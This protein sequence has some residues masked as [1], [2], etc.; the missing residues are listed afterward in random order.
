MRIIGISI[1]STAVHS[2]LTGT[3]FKAALEQ[4]NILWELY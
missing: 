1:A 4:N 3:D 2:F